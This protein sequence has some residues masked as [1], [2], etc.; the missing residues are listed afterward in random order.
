M[1]LTTLPEELLRL[2][3]QNVNRVD[4]RQVRLVHSRLGDAACTWLFH[5]L[6]VSV[7]ANQL[8]PFR[9]KNSD[10]AIVLQ[11]PL[12]ATS[13]KAHNLVQGVIVTNDV[14]DIA[15]LHCLAELP[16]MFPRISGVQLAS[17]GTDNGLYPLKSWVTFINHCA[18]LDFLRCLALNFGQLHNIVPSMGTLTKLD[19]AHCIIH[20]N[21]LSRVATYCPRLTDLACSIAA[22]RNEAAVRRFQ[23]KQESNAEQLTPPP[24]DDALDIRMELARMLRNDDNEH[25][26]IL[27]AEFTHLTRCSLRV[28]LDP[29][30][31]YFLYLLLAWKMPNVQRLEYDPV[32]QRLPVSVLHYQNSD[33]WNFMLNIQKHH[34]LRASGPPNL[35]S[36]T[37]K[38]TMIKY[39]PGQFLWGLPA[40]C[41]GLRRLTLSGL[42]MTETFG[43]PHFRSC[44]LS[45]PMQMQLCAIQGW[46]DSRDDVYISWLILPR[47]S[48]DSCKLILPTCE[49]GLAKQSVD[50]ML[51]GYKAVLL[52]E[53]NENRRTPCTLYSYGDTT[54]RNDS[55]TRQMKVQVQKRVCYGPAHDLLPVFNEVKLKLGQTRE[56][57]RR[58]HPI[59]HNPK[60]KM[61]IMVVVCDNINHLKVRFQLPS[62]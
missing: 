37:L 26:T 6:R 19:V 36:L 14:N 45:Q 27:S 47:H 58:R 9:L 25:N 1:N 60:Q 24:M 7:D 50:S 12:A 2:I 8:W 49:M 17:T 31:S 61:L 4:L 20:F 30:Q 39:I 59:S 53:S 22:S 16:Q 10:P 51:Q 33:S 21:D 3:F 62:S 29:I 54:A 55:G 52:V 34:A 43:V 23:R 41:T 57:L 56:E 48:L 42:P 5:T 32:F 40:A 13:R 11:R 44:A 38:G 15:R 28:Y 18:P 35:T 46:A